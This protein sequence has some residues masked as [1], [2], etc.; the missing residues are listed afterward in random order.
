MSR[1]G[2]APVALPGGVDVAIEGTTLTVKGTKGSL[3][4]TFSDRVSFSQTD[5]VVTVARS[6]DERDSKALHGLSRALLRNMVIG[7]SEG[8]RR[9]LNLVGVGYR[10]AASGKGVELLVG[11]SHPVKIPATEGITFDVPEPTK[12]IITGIDKELVGQVAANIRSV[13]PP[14]PY[15]GKGIKYSDEIIRRKAG[16]SGASR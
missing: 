12:I 4:R 10:A 14:E 1:I 3:S 16:K 9:E 15:K 7:V 2:N 11:Y 5:G 13:R 6:D 8:F